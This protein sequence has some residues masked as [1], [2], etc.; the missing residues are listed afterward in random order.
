MQGG[1]S[2]SMRLELAAAASCLHMHQ[3][4]TPRVRWVPSCPA[5]TEARPAIPSTH[6]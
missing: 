2:L 6:R 4:N 3:G 5:S 1:V